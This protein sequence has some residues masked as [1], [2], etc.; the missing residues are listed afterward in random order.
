[1]S[2]VDLSALRIDESNTT[3]PKRPIGPRLLVFAVIALAITV[4]AT[5][6]VP[7][8]WPP[9][10]VRMVAIQPESHSSQAST[11][12]SAEAVGWVEPDPYPFIVR[13]LVTGHI[14][15]LEVLEGAKIKA[16]ETVIAHLASAELQAAMD[17]TT[18]IV[19]ENA[20]ELNHAK[21]S[22]IMAKERLAQN[23]EAELRLKEA[24]TRLAAITTKLQV[25]NDKRKQAE[26]EVDSASANLKAQERLQQAGQS[27]EV[28]LERAH[29]EVEAKR[30]ALSASSSEFE[31]LRDEREEQRATVELCNE[32]A[33]DPVDLRGALAIAEA[34]LEKAQA[35]LKKAEV[36]A[37]IAERELGWATVRSPI[38]GIVMRLEAD[39]GDIVGHGT[40]GIVAI[41]DPQKL[42]ARIDV[43]ID[44]LRGI[45]V[46]QEVDVTS[47]AIG[48]TV[49]KGVVQRLQ[50][51]TDMLKNTLQVKIGL[52]DPPELLRPETLCRA[53]FLAGKQE[54][55]PVTVSA[56]RV[57][58]AAVQGNQVFIYD[59][60]QSIARAVPVQVVGEDGD[61]RIVRGELSPTQQVVLEPVTD[62]E[63]IQETK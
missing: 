54:D 42:R 60:K 3:V 53:R 52:I 50:H 23:A 34:D 61:S 10:A 29:A 16:N 56:F 43:P 38:D 55:G 40:G 30:A 4:A 46:G 27:F 1:M 62:G 45:H 13:P 44:S 17:R 24:L 51:V 32:L 57:P 58:A 25:A 7:M 49:V 37:M 35:A 28:A 9:R 18:A 31:G 20:A 48:N 22:Q 36:D 41:Y 8:L 26:A 15:T 63:A 33:S 21:A 47:E 19:A 12:A 39:P 11:T 6:L 2:N 14:E 59:P 5:F